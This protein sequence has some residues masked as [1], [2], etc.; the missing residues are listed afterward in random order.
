M[1]LLLVLALLACPV[2]MGLMMWWMGRTMK[3]GQSSQAEQPAAPENPEQLRDE[4]ARLTAQI[5]QLERAEQT[6]ERTR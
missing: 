5:D 2:G 6:G 3:N 4:H 1:E